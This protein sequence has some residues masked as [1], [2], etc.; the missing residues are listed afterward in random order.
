MIIPKNKVKYIN[1]YIYIYTLYDDT[2]NEWWIVNYDLE[3]KLWVNA[4]V[5][6][7]STKYSTFY[8]TLLHYLNYKNKNMFDLEKTFKNSDTNTNTNTNTKIKLIL[9]LILILKLYANTDT[10]NKNNKNK[11]K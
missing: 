2:M 6:T 3:V 1:I 10:E 9:I 4:I 7:T 5:T 11:L 8:F